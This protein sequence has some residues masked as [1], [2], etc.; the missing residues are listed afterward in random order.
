VSD[1]TEYPKKADNRDLDDE[2]Q[3]LEP[4]SV[5]EKRSLIRPKLVKRNIGAS[6]T[7]SKV[8]Q[9]GGSKPKAP[10]G[11]GPL[12]ETDKVRKLRRN[13][14]AKRAL[15]VLK[16]TKRREEALATQEVPPILE[17]DFGAG[18]STK[19]TELSLPPV[20]MSIPP[21]ELDPVEPDGIPLEEWSLDDEALSILETS[22]EDILLPPEEVI[23][24]AKNTADQQTHDKGQSS[25]GQSSD[26]EAFF[27]GL[28][29]E[30]QGL[31]QQPVRPSIATDSS[32]YESQENTKGADLPTRELQ[33]GM[34]LWESASQNN[35]EQDLD[36][37]SA[38]STGL[39]GWTLQR[40]LNKLEGAETWVGQR[41]NEAGEQGVEG[42]VKI[43]WPK[44]LSD[45]PVM[46][47]FDAEIQVRALKEL[48]HPTIPKIY[49][50]GESDDFK[51]WF[52][53]L[54][55]VE[56][57]SLTQHLRR[58]KMS[59]DE[60]TSLMIPILDG[61]A[62]CHKQSLVHRKIQPSHIILSPSGP[63]LISFQLVDEVGGE[64]LQRNQ[65]SAYQLFG[66]RPKFLAPEWM[67]DALITDAADVYALGACLLEMIN[68]QAKTWGEAPIILQASLAGAMHPNPNERSSA[69]SFLSDL[70][71]CTQ[72]YMYRSQGTTEGKEE[73][74]PI[75]EVVSR[76][77]A[78]ELGWHLLAKQNSNTDQ[79]QFVPWGEFPEIVDAVSRSKKYQPDRGL[80]PSLAPSPYPDVRFEELEA[81]E[82]SLRQRQS[83]LKK[84]EE[85]LNWREEAIR[86]K[87]RELTVRDVGLQ[88]ESNRL[89]ALQVT[90]DSKTDGINRRALELDDLKADLDQRHTSLS[91]N[92]KVVL[93][94]NEELESIRSQLEKQET[95][96]AEA[97][98]LLESEIE[99]ER[100][101][102]Q[103]ED[104][105]EQQSYQEQL[106]SEARKL[107]EEREAAL[108]AAEEAK[109]SAKVE[110]ERAEQAEK[111]TRKAYEEDLLAREE[112]RLDKEGADG[113]FARA[114]LR[115]KSSKKIEPPPQESTHQEFDL[116]GMI[117]RV[118]FCP[119]G[120]TWC[121]S[122]HEGAKNEERPRHRAKFT[123]GFWLMETPITQSQWEVLMQGNPSTVKGSDLPVEGITW[124][125][126][127]L[128]CNSLS[129]A[130]GL[131]PAYEFDG[132]PALSKHRLKIHWRYRSNGF[133]LPT[134]AEWEYA[135]RT[136][137]SGQRHTYTMGEDLNE[138]GWY[139]QNSHGRTH[140]VGIKM[141]NR[142]GLYDLCGNVW[143]WCHDEW[144]KDA[145]RIRSEDPREDPVSYNPQLTPRVVRGGA[146]YD[147]PS[148][149][150]IAARPGQDVEQT[151]GIGLRPCLPYGR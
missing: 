16:K 114:S 99:A 102:L 103:E 30:D 97:L 106:R 46:W 143:E 133:R 136:G 113:A 26:V 55:W 33:R 18:E 38:S 80:D 50:W 67:Q 108:K 79:T 131:E 57:V 15:E 147:Y 28:Y 66:Q 126:A 37:R 115:S 43:V 150:R 89:E 45:N 90:L 64:D 2:D 83:E 127:A 35:V 48:D 71:L 118:R 24:H 65:Q 39:Q 122:D 51:A 77:R 119:P 21:I 8:K 40:L 5:D 44:V 4:Q 110:K 96:R 148:A 7:E 117:L 74:L 81:R 135:A 68:P 123:S 86:E 145:Y 6:L 19:E 88:E 29:S 54:E 63:K 82:A 59:I 31:K 72:N 94:Q 78:S 56:G 140:P 49:A 112:A 34:V 73:R 70:K 120:S 138:I 124:V 93:D 84:R 22:S 1:P 121:G 75:H 125:E 87:E 146:W 132:D 12:T 107:I 98:A 105:L 142:W 141:A 53:V 60:A 111:A 17:F 92:E 134:E 76:I 144:R 14:A 69:A 130:F 20:E 13:R 91:D 100:A 47:Q 32:S 42:T 52:A 23:T 109:R 41:V 9:A 62:E 36:A 149:C 25:T 3:Y 129:S 61:L 27:Q 58:N 104:R 151:Y 139:T 85:E 95:E 101:R 128:Y 116:D 11:L 137:L 10:R